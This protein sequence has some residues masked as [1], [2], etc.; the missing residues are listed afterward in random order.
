MKG[1]GYYN[2]LRSASEHPRLDAE[3]GGLPA[4]KVFTWL[5]HGSIQHE[6]QYKTDI[7]LSK[8]KK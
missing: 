5:M 4:Y 8:Q 6:I 3:V 2:T 1:F 7:E